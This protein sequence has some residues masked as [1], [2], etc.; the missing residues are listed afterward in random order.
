MP[1]DLRFKCGV[2]L[3]T[4]QIALKEWDAQIRTLETGMCALLFRKGGIIE[5]RGEFSVEHKQFWLYPTFL[6]QNVG[7]LKVQHH[8]QLRHNPNPG[9]VRLQSY[10]DVAAAYKLE[11]LATVARLEPHNPLGMAALEQ[12]FAY[13]QLPYVYALLLRVYTCVPT[14]MLETSEYAGCVSWVSFDQPVVPQEVT[15]V[16]SDS[17]FQSLQQQI[18]SLL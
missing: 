7:E 13:R 17:T 14:N 3:P 12:K 9:T 1:R 8:A 18:E 4:M 15:P 6:H 5:K 10:A 11:D 2:K 16:L